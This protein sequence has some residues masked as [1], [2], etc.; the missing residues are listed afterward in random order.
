MSGAAPGF[1]Q[2]AV[3]RRGRQRLDAALGLGALLY[4]WSASGASRQCT[5]RSSCARTVV[6]A[7]HTRSSAVTE[8]TR[9]ASMLHVNEYFVNSLKVILNVILEKGTSPY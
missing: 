4:T 2:H 3:G 7:L 9:V 1:S 6:I 8:R 5:K